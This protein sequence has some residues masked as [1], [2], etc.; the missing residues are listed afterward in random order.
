MRG[1]A[2]VFVANIDTV[3]LDASGPSESATERNGRET[4]FRG[5][6]SSAVLDLN[7]RLKLRQV[8]EVAPIDRKVL[9][10]LGREHT[11]DRGLFRV[12]AQCRA[13]DLNHF[14]RLSKRQDHA[15]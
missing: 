9:D 12:Y 8:E 11:L 1:G 2:N 15:P 4:V 6:E 5:I 14:G 13:F 7:S 10:L 3:N